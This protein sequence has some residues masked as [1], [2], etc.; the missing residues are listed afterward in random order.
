M[1]KQN[2][3]SNISKSVYYEARENINTIDLTQKAMQ[4][5]ISFWQIIVPA[6]LLLPFYYF[7]A[8]GS[9]DYR[10]LTLTDTSEIVHP[11]LATEFID[12]EL[13]A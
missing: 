13:F 11:P 6:S 10:I 9:G 7:D 1:Q 4:S 3:S 8:S 5:L 2:N 12:N